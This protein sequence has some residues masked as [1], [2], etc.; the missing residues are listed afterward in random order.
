MNT[1]Q[2]QDVPPRI[3]I[4]DDDQVTRLLLREF[5]EKEG[6]SVVE[7]RNG[8]ECLAAYQ[9]NQSDI[10]LLDA[11]MPGMD[12]FD[13]CKKL[14]TLPGSK[15]TPVL[16]ITGLEDES[17]IDRAFEVGAA[18]YLTKPIHWAVLRQ[19]IPRLIEKSRLHRKLEETN[20]QLKHLAAIDSLT[21]IFNRRCF[22]EYLSIQWLR[23]A[24]NQ[25]PLSLI[26]CDV[27]FFK[28]YND[29][30]GHPA[31]DECLKA[32]ARA[33]SKAV[34]RPATLVARYGGEEFAV[35]LPNT[36]AVSA[37]HVAQNMRCAVKALQIT[38]ANSCASQW[39][40]L[41]QGIASLV[42]SR[43]ST[44][45]TLISAADRALYRAKAQ[46]RDRVVLDKFD[47]EYKN[48]SPLSQKY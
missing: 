43:E 14:Q 35:I 27:D 44:A 11:L 46:G 9:C 29:T 45:Q 2:I 12:G 17:S 28:V 3:L 37:T 7:A 33:I 25:S 42:P 16:M 30:Y 19:R 32:V 47:I 15:H 5:F 41:S 4:A 6:Y 34:K 13:C 18:D 23:M 40:T 1:V 8:N 26:L 20:R 36:D 39:V 31:G 10:V 38:H 22:D 21:Q 24:N 48:T